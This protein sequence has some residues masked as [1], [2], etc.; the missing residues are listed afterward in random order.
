MSM[1]R[2]AIVIGGGVPGLLATKALSR[3]F[4][5]VTLVERDQL[6]SGP[7]HRSG[8]PQSHHIH[9][10]IRGG[11]QLFEEY[12]PGLEARLFEAGA[13]KV[14]I[15]HDLKFAAGDGWMPRF[16]ANIHL[17]ACSR[18]LLESILRQFLAR[19]A[20]A[21]VL[22]GTTVTGLTK[23][24]TGRI[25][26]VSTREHGELRADF[27]VNASG[28]NSPVLKWFDELGYQRP[29]ENVVD[30]HVGYSTRRFRRP[31]D[32]AA[33]WKMLARLPL[34]P[35]DRRGTVIYPEEDDTWT[36]TLAG[37]EKDYPPTDEEGFA[38]FVRSRGPEFS[39]ALEAA[40]PISSIRGFRFEGNRWRRFDRLARLPERFVTLGD[41]LCSLNPVYS[42]G[43]TLGSLCVKALDEVLRQSG[44]A[45]DGVS[46]RAQRKFNSVVE[47]VWTMSAGSDCGWPTYEGDPQ[48][49]RSK[50]ILWYRGQLAKLSV[51]DNTVRHRL[52]EVHHLV[53]PTSALFAPSMAARLLKNQLRLARA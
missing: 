30:G 27:I 47:P 19:E 28:R 45:L 1:E 3:H 33:D 35:V 12:F 7:E 49:L 20:K 26:G 42:Q 4:D 8:V 11:Q 43:M 31:A 37:A 53:K 40:E 9:L 15:G 5:R 38:E 13:V 41:A 10:L 2:T 51:G 23:D 18:A 48:P 46:E 29:V 34:P 50:A 17:T 39:R 36:I 16:V 21:Q 6:P 44:G 52:L 32:F 22:D 24:A 14:D 25:G